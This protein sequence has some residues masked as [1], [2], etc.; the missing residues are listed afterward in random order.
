MPKALTPLP[1]MG[2]KAILAEWL[3][4]LLPQEFK[5]TYVEPFGGQSAVFYRRPRSK[6]EVIN[7]LNDRLVNWSITLRNHSA[8]F[9]RIL[10][11]TLQWSQSEFIWA[12][13]NIDNQ[14]L[15]RPMRALAYFLVITNSRIH[16]DSP[17]GLRHSAFT[18]QVGGKWWTGH[19]IKALSDRLQRVII[20]CEDAV[21]CMKYHAKKKNTV[22]YVD[23]PYYSIDR[24]DEYYHHSDV[25]V[26]GLTA[27]LEAQKGRV[28]LSGYDD[29]WD[30]LRWIRHE[31]PTNSS[32]ASDRSKRIEVAW[33]NYEIQLSMF[34]E[35]T[36]K[37]DTGEEVD[38]DG[39]G[40]FYAALGE[41]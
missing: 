12:V 29:E 34:D 2:G 8:E 30:H 35:N 40:D 36:G 6:V 26:A 13:D 5:S 20:T 11:A 38:D 21:D 33:A 37:I 32:M 1:Y 22:M 24:I 10:E 27:A 18:K 19:E 3:L 31:R 25:D 28:L 17:K 16:T 15:D 41:F 23:P 7:D 39:L 9:I 14:E 4:G